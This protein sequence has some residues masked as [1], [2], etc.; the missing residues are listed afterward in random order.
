MFRLVFFV[1]LCNFPK[2]RLRLRCSYLFCIE[3][4][5]EI[6]IAGCQTCPAHLPTC[7]APR[8]RARFCGTCRRKW[9]VRVRVRRC[10]QH[11]G[12]RPLLDLPL[13]LPV[14]LTILHRL[15]LGLMD[16]ATFDFRPL[17][18]SS[19]FEPFVSLS[20]RNV[21]PPLSETL[22]FFERLQ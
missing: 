9:R 16:S 5:L 21:F 19:R 10:A 6:R 3:L 12:S 4:T 22:R 7:P 1:V 8:P 20:E 2:Q 17:T 15:P 18:L 11:G 13:F 14:L